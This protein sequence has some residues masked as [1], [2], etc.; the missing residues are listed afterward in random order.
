MPASCLCRAGRFCDDACRELGAARE[1][2]TTGGQG[3]LADRSA[4]EPGQSQLGNDEN[5]QRRDENLPEKS[6]PPHGAYSLKR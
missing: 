2:V 5:D 3:E 1:V 6:R 4:G